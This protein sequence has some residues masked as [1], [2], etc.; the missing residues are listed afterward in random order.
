MLKSL[1]KDQA[2]VLEAKSGRK[3][4]QS[5]QKQEKKKK[6][7]TENTDTSIEVIEV[8][9]AESVDQ[10]EPNLALKEH[11]I[12]QNTEA[13]EVEKSHYSKSL[14][15]FNYVPWHFIGKR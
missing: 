6:T 10:T 12:Q 11:D 5:K 13:P 8:F 1:T 3:G 15:V 4:I 7:T 14:K 2:M 9:A